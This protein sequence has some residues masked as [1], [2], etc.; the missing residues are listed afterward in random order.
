MY[1]AEDTFAIKFRRVLRKLNEN[2]TVRA[3]LKPIEI[4]SQIPEL[5]LPTL[6]DLN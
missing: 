3:V 4:V 6:E 2:A 1:H 5:S